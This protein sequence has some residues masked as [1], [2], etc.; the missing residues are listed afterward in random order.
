MYSRHSRGFF[1]RSV[2]NRTLREAGLQ[3]PHFVFIFCTKTR[4]TLTPT[5]GSHLA[6]KVGTAA[7]ICSRYQLGDNI[8]LSVVVRSL[9]NPQ[10]QFVVLQLDSRRGGFLNEFQQVA[11]SPYVVALA[12]QVLARRFAFLFAQ[13]RLLLLDPAQFGNREK[14]DSAELHAMRG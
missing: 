8:F 13:L 12:V 4:C 6:I 14:T 1:A 7:L 11:L 5:V 10:N 3:L 9:V 2:F